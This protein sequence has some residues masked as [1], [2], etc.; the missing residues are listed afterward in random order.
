MASCTTFGPWADPDAALRKYLEQKDRLHAGLVPR[1]AAGSMTLRDL[2]NR[3]MTTKTMLRDAGELSIHSWRDYYTVCSRLIDGLGPDRLLADI[4]PADFE[5]LRAAWARKWGPVRLGNEINKT[6]VL[7]NYGYKNG[8]LD[9]P[10]RYGEGFKRPSRRLLRL[11]R[12]AK[13][14]RMFEADELR[15][16][17]EAADQPLQSMILL[18][19]NCALGNSDVGH[20]PINA[21]D[22]DHGWLTYPR[23]KTGITRHCPLWPETVAALRSWLNQRPAPMTAAGNDLVFVTSQGGTWTKA[24]SRGN[25]SAASSF[26]TPRNKEAG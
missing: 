10:I 5:R 6:R 16:V 15:R 12:A 9:R 20:L 7:F 11:A 14:L 2:C 22:L 26:A 4:Q 3:F 17:I 23:P 13:G 25:W 21:L 1:D 8:M 19:I 18:G 24:T